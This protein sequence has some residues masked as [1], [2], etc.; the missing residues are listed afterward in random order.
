MN[1]D[2]NK[3][4]KDK[5][6]GYRIIKKYFFL[7][8]KLL[9]LAG[10]SMFLA[11]F[12]SLVIPLIAKYAI[13]VNLANNDLPGLRKTSTFAAS[14]GFTLL[15]AKFIQ[16]R[17]VGNLG[18]QIL[19][20]LRH[21]LFKKLQKLPM[22][23]FTQNTSGDLINRISSN[24]ESINK[25]FSSSLLKTVNASLKIVGVSIAM[26]ML[27]VKLAIIAIIPLFCIAIFLAIQGTFLKA[28]LKSALVCKADIASQIQDTTS[29]I[30]TIKAFGRE[31][32]FQKLL[33]GKSDIYFKKN[34]KSTFITTLSQT[35]MGLFSQ[36]GTILVLY[37]ALQAVGSNEITMGALFTFLIYVLQFYKPV[38]MIGPL[39]QQIQHS[40]AAT[41]RIG[42]IMNL[43]NPLLNNQDKIKVRTQRKTGD[44]KQKQKNL[45]DGIYSPTNHEIKGSVEF[46]N[47]TFQ[48]QDNA[49]VLQNISFKIKAGEKVGLIGSTGSGKT[50]FVNLISRL[51]D[52]NNGQ[53]LVD[54]VNVQNWDIHALRGAIGYLL[55]NVFMF[56]NSVL[57]NLT[58]SNP[59]I[60]RYKIQEILEKLQAN[61][62]ISRLPNDLNT[63]ID[64]SSNLLSIGEK[65]VLAIARTLLSKPK[66]LILD[67]ATASIDTRYEKIVQQ[68]IEIATSNVTSFIIAHR[69]STIENVDKIILLKYNSILESGTKDELLTQKGEFYRMYKAFHS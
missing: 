10:L 2:L 12:L 5:T 27:D 13:D 39:W 44:L 65:Q 19:Y 68:A 62:F 23:F 25:L 60:S 64:D 18:Q 40:I 59:K 15:I 26:F 4:K 51:Y 61:K 43:E 47:V 22:E 7:E 55:Q 16:T 52:V 50:T 41:E 32:F 3:I 30:T 36:F 9:L 37:F 17:I 54:G 57:N 38:R 42:A 34:F 33:N 58:F 45:N 1:Y 24:V 6:T 56:N 48:Y 35:V 14:T 31:Q 67:E 69:L 29:G 11:T 53:I 66:I 8:W 28:A 49:P 21:D 46:Q 63:Q 20:N